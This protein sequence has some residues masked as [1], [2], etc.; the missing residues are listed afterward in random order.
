MVLRRP[1]ESAQYT[2]V[3]FSQH[4]RDAGLV[5]SM[6]S[7]GDSYDNALAES[8][9]GTLK[10]EVVD[11]R[12][13]PTR[14]AAQLAIFEYVERWYNRRRRHSALDYLSPAEYER[15]W[16]AGVAVA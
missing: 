10:G 2:S 16:A 13:W 5:A 7:V 11:R 15:L 1:V 9:F 6:G 4:L 8:F 14:A 3:A 12:P